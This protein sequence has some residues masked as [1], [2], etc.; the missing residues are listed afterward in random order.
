[1]ASDPRR[2]AERVRARRY[3][4]RARE[5]RAEASETKAPTAPPGLI[6]FALL[7]EILADG[8]DAR[9][10]ARKRLALSFSAVDAIMGNLLV[11][12]KPRRVKMRTRSPLRCTCRR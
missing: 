7:C 2:V 9:L 5:C 12:L 11:Q 6:Q 1:M 4:E 8:I 10:A 3:R